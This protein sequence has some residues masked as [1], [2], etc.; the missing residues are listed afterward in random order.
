[1]VAFKQLNIR[2]LFQGHLENHECFKDRVRMGEFSTKKLFFLQFFHTERVQELILD[3]APNFLD[4]D[5]KCLPEIVGQWFQNPVVLSR[6][7]FEIR[8]I[9]FTYMKDARGDRCRTPVSKVK[10]GKKKREKATI[11]DR[12]ANGALVVIQ[13]RYAT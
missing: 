7:V 3:S 4:Y 11:L 13:R 2:N 10:R 8:F 5:R 6:I 9:H 12:I 1:M